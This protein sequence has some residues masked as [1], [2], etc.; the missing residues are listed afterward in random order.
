[1]T[2]FLDFPATAFEAGTSFWRALTAYTL[3]PARGA[4]EEFATLVPESGDAF[5]RVQRTAES[6][7][8]CHLDL[9]VERVDESAEQAVC[10]GASVGEE[11]PGIVVMTSPGGLP[12]C[13]VRHRGE[14]HRP[15]P[16]VWSGGHR[17]L[18]DQLCLDIP[19]G[20]PA[21]EGAFWAAFTG[22][23][24]R[25]GSRPEFDYLVRP[26]GMPLRLLVQRLDDGGVDRC[27]SH[28][29]FACD[30]VD[31]EVHRHEAL[32]ASVVRAMTNWTTLV[33]P[34]GMRYCVTGR[35]PGPGGALR[36]GV[37]CG[38]AGGQFVSS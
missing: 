19:P 6:T 13:V 24:R 16:K 37:G 22:W 36:A 1:M 28:L 12:F 5:L 9:H 30:D 29:D 31:A 27:A 25:P 8:R 2:A 7:P 14:E 23:E 34:T 17:S 11:R 35:N 10:L 32:G 33:D 3:S 21:D 26:A 20:A 38:G 15:A 18:V 4:F